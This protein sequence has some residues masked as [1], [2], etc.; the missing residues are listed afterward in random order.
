MKATANEHGVVWA[1][2]RNG[3]LDI[4]VGERPGGPNRWSVWALYVGTHDLA[5]VT[6]NFRTEQEARKYANQVWER[7]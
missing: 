4:A 3:K 7:R 1:T 2:S 6:R 5:P